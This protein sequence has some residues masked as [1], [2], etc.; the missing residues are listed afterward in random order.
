MTNITILDGGMGQELVARYPG[1][2]TGLWST[3]VLLD[4]PQLVRAVHDDYF[5]AGAEIAT[6]NTYAIHHDRLRDADLDHRFEELHRSACEMAAAARDAN[7]SGLVAGS[8]GPLGWSYRPDLAPPVEQAAELYAEIAAIQAP[9]VDLFICET[10]ASVDQARGGVLGAKTAGK[11]VWLAVTVDDDDGTRL[12]SGEP[13]LELLPLLQ[14]T[15]PAAVLVN[16]SVP[17]ALDTALPLLAGQ[18]LPTGGYAN[19]FVSI[20]DSFAQKNATVNELSAREDLD[21]QQYADFAR[22]WVDAGATIIGGCCEVGPAHIAELVKRFR[23][24]D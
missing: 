12:R 22:H 18:G 7:G 2:A 10:M 17:E 8:L 21:P 3:Q 11:P 20:T 15:Q 1:A 14:E 24:F 6:T 16:C 23:Q 9:H 4:E 5:A 13:L 19:G